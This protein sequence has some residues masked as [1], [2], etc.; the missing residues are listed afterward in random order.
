M[1]KRVI[2]ILVERNEYIDKTE[3]QAGICA[4][5]SISSGSPGR[6][7]RRPDPVAGKAEKLGNIHIT[8]SERVSFRIIQSLP[9]EAIAILCAFFAADP[10]K[11]RKTLKQLAREAGFVSVEDY[12]V[13]RGRA[14]QAVIEKDQYW[15]PS[16]YFK[17]K[18][19]DA[20]EPVLKS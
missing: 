14:E 2:E 13:A 3:Q 7:S 11:C 9:H 17:V 19:R 8:K 6:G 20:R 16:I 10:T 18:T 5:G 15:N 12:K 1:N 4:G